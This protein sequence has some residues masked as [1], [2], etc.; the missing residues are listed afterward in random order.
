ML[1]H[2]GHFGRFW[3]IDIGRKCTAAMQ[4]WKEEVKSLIRGI[5]FNIKGIFDFK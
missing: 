1:I 3:Q 5:H 4:M 2:F